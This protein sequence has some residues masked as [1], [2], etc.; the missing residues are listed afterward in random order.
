MRLRKRY[1]NWRFRRACR[2]HP[3]KAE[4]LRQAFGELNRTAERGDL[5]CSALADALRSLAH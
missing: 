2:R 4:R 5:A 1:R 3:E